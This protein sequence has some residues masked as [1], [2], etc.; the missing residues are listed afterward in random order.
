MGSPLHGLSS[1]AHRLENILVAGAAAAISSDSLADVLLRRILLAAQQVERGEQ[2]AGRAVSALQ[3]VMLGK[4]L[5]HG[6]QL[7]ILLQAFN[8]G[9]FALVRLKGKERARLHG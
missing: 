9:D 3:S 1:S 5:L 8:R 2:H 6:M 7:A 4:G